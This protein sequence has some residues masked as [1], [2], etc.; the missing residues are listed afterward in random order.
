MINMSEFDYLITTLF[1]FMKQDV[2]PQK[3]EV[4]PVRDTQ[5]GEGPVSLSS[6]SLQVS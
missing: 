5:W 6:L 2:L 1:L 3:G 4:L